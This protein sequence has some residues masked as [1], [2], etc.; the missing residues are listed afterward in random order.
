M[1]RLPVPNMARAVSV[2]IA[3]PGPRITRVFPGTD[4]PAAST[5]CGE[6]T[7]IDKGGRRERLF[8]PPLPWTVWWRSGGAPGD[9]CGYLFAGNY[10]LHKPGKACVYGHMWCK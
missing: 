4:V 5:R 3:N 9:A 1:L 8:T 7:D 10:G 2:T 6:A